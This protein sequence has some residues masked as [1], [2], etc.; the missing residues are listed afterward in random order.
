M[1]DFQEYI[2]ALDLMYQVEIATNPNEAWDDL[3]VHI[4]AHFPVPETASMGNVDWEEI[5]KH[6]ECQ[7]M[8]L[9][10]KQNRDEIV[11]KLCSIP[12]VI[13]AVSF[14]V[15]IARYLLRFTKVNVSIS[16]LKTFNEF[17]RRYGNMVLAA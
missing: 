10:F 7:D 11:E 13:L 16:M 3:Y 12:P 2:T 1:N 14:P 6:F 4:Y 17:H 9:M 5:E 8:E 15:W